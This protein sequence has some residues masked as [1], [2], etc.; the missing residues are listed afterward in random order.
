LQSNFI[1]RYSVNKKNNKTATP[2]GMRP[3]GPR[4][5]AATPQ[6]QSHHTAARCP[7]SDWMGTMIL[8]TRM[9][10]TNW[11]FITYYYELAVGKTKYLIWSFQ[12]VE[13]VIIGVIDVTVDPEF[14]LYSHR[15]CS[16][17][18]WSRS[19]PQRFISLLIQDIS[20]SYRTSCASVHTSTSSLSQ[21]FAQH[22]RDINLPHT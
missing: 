5:A 6:T 12:R 22:T 7:L 10:Q 16:G 15:W 2:I 20:S 19:Q 1:A 11:M 8:L 18:G 9:R 4:N 3:W 13:R 21:I 17:S 14:R